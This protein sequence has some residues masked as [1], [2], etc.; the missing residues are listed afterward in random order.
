MAKL[1][2]TAVNFVGGG[3]SRRSNEMTFHLIFVMN[4]GDGIEKI[5]SS[6]TPLD[7]HRYS[8]QIHIIQDPG[9]APFAVVYDYSARILWHGV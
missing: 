1:C 7:I 2:G 6:L 4:H 9:F 8:I 3:K 5:G